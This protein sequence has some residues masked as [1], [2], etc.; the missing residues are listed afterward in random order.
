VYEEK[1]TVLGKQTH[2]TQS[3]IVSVT[4]FPLYNSL[5]SDFIY[6]NN[7]S[8]RRMKCYEFVGKVKPKFP[9]CPGTMTKDIVIVDYESGRRRNLTTLKH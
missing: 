8:C 7:Y 5:P 2:K 3:T 4:H 6:E 9:L 1:T